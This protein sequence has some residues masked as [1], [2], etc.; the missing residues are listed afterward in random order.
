M[1]ERGPSMTERGP[2]IAERRHGASPVLHQ[3][4]RSTPPSELSARARSIVYLPAPT[5]CEGI[6]VASNERPSSLVSD[7][8]SSRLSAS[9]RTPKLDVPSCAGLPRELRC[10]SPPFVH[11]LVSQRIVGCH[12]EEPLSYLV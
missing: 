8:T 2:S 4:L 7:V 9:L 3:M 6:A 5:G 12:M 1:T 11:E 10:T